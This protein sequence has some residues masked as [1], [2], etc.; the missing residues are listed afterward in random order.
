MGIG[1]VVLDIEDLCCDWIVGIQVIE[2]LEDIEDFVAICIMLLFSSIVI[3][4]V[5]QECAFCAV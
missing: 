1:F 2:D 5:F 4:F 3:L